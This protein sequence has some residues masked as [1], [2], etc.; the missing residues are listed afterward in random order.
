MTLAVLGA[1]TLAV[2][3]AITAQ[4]SVGLRSMLSLDDAPLPPARTPRVSVVV[5]ARDEAADVAR[6]VDALRRQ[7]YP[8]YEVVVVN[9]RS[10]D[11][12]GAIL[13]R[14]AAGG[15]T[16][17]AADRKTARLHVIHVRELPDGWLGKNHALQRGAETASGDVLLFT[18]A[19]VVMGPDAVARAVSLLDAE[20]LDHL[21]VAPRLDGGSLMTR[22]VVAVFM[23]AFSALFRPWKARDRKSRHHIGIGAFNMV[24]R[25]AYEAIGGHRSIAMRPDDDV[26]LGRRLKEEG[27][28][29]AAATG[30]GRVE[31]EW[32]PTVGAMARGFRKNAFAVVNYRLSLVAVGTLIPVLLILWPVAALFVTSGPTWWLNLGVVLLG[33]VTVGDTARHHDL[34]LRTVLLYPLAALLL[35]G[36]VWAAALRAVSRGSVEW[37]GTE[38]PLDRLRRDG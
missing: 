7:S 27:F 3:A 21:A 35:L 29:Q 5:A 14:L 33:L 28:A 12:T 18:D 13:E 20:E 19:D 26:R 25:S 30:R 32:Y 38:Y 34:P 36:M 16:T 22:A 17:R 23:V 4:L 1:V 15:G 24:R 8:D 2:A 10:S 37:R 6:S 31:V 9:D 11:G